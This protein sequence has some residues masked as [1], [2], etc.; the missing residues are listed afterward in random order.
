MKKTRNFYNL[1]ANLRRE[2]LFKLSCLRKELKKKKLRL[3]FEE[4]Q[5]IKHAISIRR[6][7][8]DYQKISAPSNFSFIENEEDTLVFIHS[9][10]DCYRKRRKT[11]INLHN[12]KHVTNDALVLLLSNMVRF[13][14]SNRP[15]NGNFP[16]DKK[17]AKII[18]E[19]GFLE[20]LYDRL[21]RNSVYDLPGKSNSFHTHANKIVD[22]IK[23]D[24]II[25]K[26]SITIWGEERRCKQV[27][28]AF[29][30][31]MQNTMNHA[32]DIPGD[33]HWWLTVSHDKENRKVTISF[34]DFGKG[35]FRSLDE[36][37]EDD[38]FYNW[39]E[40]IKKYW[41]LAK[42]NDQK[43][44]LIF[45]GALYKDKPATVTRNY[46][47]GKGLPGIYKAMKNNDLVNLVVITNNVYA[48]VSS[49]EYH[50]MSREFEGTFVSWEMNETI[51]SLL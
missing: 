30:E 23:T 2:K 25:K 24:D 18:R 6:K 21:K 20:S 9:V 19:S 51:N 10:I 42:S 39:K 36:K 13:R 16:R 48:N 31:L 8:Y 17:C 37:K 49:E 11:F 38:K 32:A 12:V 41:P 7:F 43:L 33:K 26:A 1:H 3:P 14:T 28:R 34:V 15:F 27:Q 4:Q 22:Q 35:V 5:N 46:Y 29:I 47:R 50:L 40:V 44:K 45:E